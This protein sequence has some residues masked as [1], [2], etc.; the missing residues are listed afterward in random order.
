[1]KPAD[2]QLS[3]NGFIRAIE[4]MGSLL[5]PSVKDPFEV[6]IYMCPRASLYVCARVC[7]QS[8]STVS[9]F[10]RVEDP[11]E[12]CIHI[13]VCRLGSLLVVALA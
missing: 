12:V 7:T 10:L 13:S 1:M 5:F 9:L 3:F 6:C 4:S 2:L 8:H 11:F